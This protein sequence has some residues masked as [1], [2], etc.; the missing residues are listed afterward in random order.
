MINYDQQNRHSFL[1]EKSELLGGFLGI[2][3]K[4]PQNIRQFLF[5]RLLHII[6]IVLTVEF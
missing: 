1:N 3:M 4:R 2:L 5:V 6:I